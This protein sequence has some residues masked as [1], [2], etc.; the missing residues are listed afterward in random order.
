MSHAPIW[1]STLVLSL[2]LSTAPSSFAQ[3]SG[4][5][6][7]AGRTSSATTS[8]ADASPAA[9]STPST[10]TALVGS[11]VKIRTNG[12]AFSQESQVEGIKGENG[13]YVH[14]M[15]LH[16]PMTHAPKFTLN[17]KGKSY[18]INLRDYHNSSL[19]IEGGATIKVT[20][21]V[22]GNTIYAAKIETIKEPMKEIYIQ[23]DIKEP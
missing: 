13:F 16:G 20:G 12:S 11:I 7:S 17:V 1:S 15:D 9:N 10:P 18:T 6:Q 19:S 21:V 2:A 3:T 23:T 14:K 8:K 4:Q 5:N 22:V